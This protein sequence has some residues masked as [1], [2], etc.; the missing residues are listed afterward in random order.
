[1]ELH[2]TKLEIISAFFSVL[3]YICELINCPLNG[4]PFFEVM[5]WKNLP[6]VWLK[7]NGI[8]LHLWKNVG[9]F[10]VDL[11]L[12]GSESCSWFEET[13]GWTEL[14]NYWKKKKNKTLFCWDSKFMENIMWNIWLILIIYFGS[15]WRL[16]LPF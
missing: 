2:R 9:K 8:C 3:W 5:L 16:F 12:L 4:C 14:N 15:K 1:M 7:Y 6:N 10:Y 11:G 13:Y